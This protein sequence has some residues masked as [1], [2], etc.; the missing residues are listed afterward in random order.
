MKIT[1]DLDV[2]QKALDIIT[3][4]APPVS[5]A[6]T[7]MSSK[8]KLR[9]FSQGELGRCRVLVPCEVVGDG[10]FAVPLEALKN[11]IKG[12]KKLNLSLANAM[13][14]I[15]SGAYKAKLNTVDVIPEDELDQEEVKTSTITPEQAT[16]LKQALRSVALRP[17]TIL[18]SWMPV[19]IVINAKGAFVACYDENHMS[20]TRSSKVTGDLETVMPIE[21]MAMLLD[22]FQATDFTISQGKAYMTIKNKLVTATLSAPKVDDL[23]SV[24]DV[25]SRTQ[26]AMKMKANEVQFVKA[27]LSA[28][29]DNARAVIGKERPELS[30]EA[31]GKAVTLEVQ[32]GQGHVKSQIKASGKAKF[33]VD[34]EYLSE[35]LAKAGAEVTLNV[36]E[37][38]FLAIKLETSTSLM[39][40]NQ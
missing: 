1:T 31:D 19:G 14:S 36:V 30:L 12:R 15:S 28:F 26:E 25:R 37:D 38:A 11:A 9:L 39:G 16:W 17:T 40:L 27:D 3:R 35:L 8:G 29:I 10:E 6:V 24:A 21:T 7:F 4:V 20:W 22:L 33:K 2:L 18:S 13:L 34:L 32:T 23:H 5:E